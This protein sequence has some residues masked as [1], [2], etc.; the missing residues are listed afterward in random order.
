M[1]S[2][3]FDSEVFVDRESIPGECICGQPK[4]P[5]ACMACGLGSLPEVK[6]GSWR[7]PEKQ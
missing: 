4:G 5:D 2:L 3:Y 1:G 6:T 7:A